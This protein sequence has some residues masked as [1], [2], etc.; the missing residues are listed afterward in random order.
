M[1]I[2]I[3][4]PVLLDPDRQSGISI[5]LDGIFNYLKKNGHNVIVTDKNK[6]AIFKNTEFIYCLVSTKPDSITTKVISNMN[7]NNKLILDLYT[8]ILLE[9]RF[10]FSTFNP[11]HLL[12]Q[13]LQKQIIK[14]A[15]KKATYYTVANRKQRKYWERVSGKLGHNISDKDI[16]VIPTSHNFHPKK[17]KNKKVV[18]WFGGIYPWLD[19]TPLAGAFL[20]IAHKFP[21]WK[22]RILGGYYEG[23]G[24]GKIYKDFT[25]VLGNIPDNQ[26]EIIPWQNRNYLPNYL[27]DVTFAAHLPKDA[28][29]DLYAHRVRLLTLT[30]SQIPVLTSGKDT[31]S[32]IILKNKAGIKITA[33]TDKLS[34]V[35]SEMISN[36]GLIGMMAKNTPKV[37]K[38]FLKEELKDPIFNQ[39]FLSQTQ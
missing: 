33:E 3:V 11:T 26:L 19:P 7:V 20:K 23:T 14:E 13:R 29:E 31:I 4:S 21:K 9:K 8:P 34:K 30:N 17:S 10:S 28:E 18:L 25:K 39:P 38:V 1:R 37:E 16:A 5:R 32:K 2:I 24:Y 15:L 6:K 35:L 36:P 12:N 22:F 27:G